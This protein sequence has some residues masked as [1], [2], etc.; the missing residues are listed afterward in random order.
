MM[1]MQPIHQQ[2]QHHLTN[3]YQRLITPFKKALDTLDDHTHT[4]ADILDLDKYTQAEVDGFLA[5]KADV[6]SLSSTIILYPTTAAADIATYFRLVDSI[7]DAD[8][9]TT[10]VNVPTGAV[11]GQNVLISSLAA[12]A[13]L[14]IGNPGVINI[15]VLGKIR[16][17]A[18]GANQGAEFYYEV[19]LRNAGGTETLLATSDTTRTVTAATYQEF[20]ASALL[21][22]GQFTATD[23]LVYKFYGNNV[24]GGDP[25]FDFEFGGDTPVR[26]LLPLPVNVTLQANK[27]FYDNTGQNLVATNV[28]DAI[29][30][31]DDLVEEGL[32]QVVVVK[33]E[34]TD[35]DDTAG[36]FIYNRND[37]TGINGTKDNGKFVFT[38]P[39]G[40]EY[41]TGGNRLSVKID[42]SDGALK[43]L[44]YGADSELTEPS[45]TTFAIDFALVDNDVL[46]AKLYQSLATVSLDIADGSVTEA[47]I[48]NGAVTTNK[49]ANNAVDLTKVQQIAT[50]TI[51]GNDTGGTANVKALTAS[52][53]KV[54]LALNNVDNTSDLNKPISSNTQTALDA[55][56]AGPASAVNNQI[57]VF[58]GTTGKIIKDS[59]FTIETSVPAGAVFTDT[60]EDNIIEEV[61]AEGV[62]L[63]ITAKAVNVTRAALGAGTG[64]ADVFFFTTTIADTDWTGSEAPYTA[65]KTVSGLLSTDRPIVDLDLSAVAIGNVAAKQS[66]WAL[67]Y[68]AAA[69]DTDELSFFATEEPTES[70][71][72]QIKVVR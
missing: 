21:N 24:G 46:Y 69:T 62:A 17:T 66:D 44:F 31:I 27:V 52:E 39:T 70:L 5:D 72:I 3:Y 61:Q 37:E 14:F 18:G 38:L 57:A 65:V 71:V 4:E 64:D 20:F 30:E 32:T 12:D 8:Y 6:A 19:Y 67:V 43:R 50:N 34:I 22:N 41:V 13:G 56:V 51:L 26:A 2:S 40:I 68:R 29:N 42:G 53:T 59:G 23:R 16:K 35:A 9:D 60:G 55:K 54:L 7:N 45:D 48:A 47:K 28:Q 49:L 33:Y 1:P 10:A 58:D 63:A 11:S 25:E 36:G 15:T